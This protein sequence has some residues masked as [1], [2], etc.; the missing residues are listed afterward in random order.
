MHK[1]IIF[2]VY[3]GIQNSVFTSQVLKPLQNLLNK[4]NKVEIS[5]ISFEKISKKNFINIIKQ[6]NS[7]LKPQM[8]NKIKF[9][10]L[11]KLPLITK[12]SLLFATY[13]LNKILKRTSFT[14][15]IARGPLAGWIAIKTLKKLKQTNM[16]ITIQ[17]R[18]LCAQEYRFTFQ[19]LKESLIKK[20]FRKITYK[21][22]NTIEKEVY[23]IKRNN[24]T[25]ESVSPALKNYLI[26][27]FETNKNQIIIASQD[28][29]EKI[30]TNK[31]KNFRKIIREKLN[32]PPD[33]FVY[34]YS[35]SAKPWQC[36]DKAI[37]YFSI[38]LKNN[39]NNFLLIL[40][41][42]QKQIEKIIKQNKI[43]TKNFH[44]IN[45]KPKKLHQYLAACDA[46]LLFRDKDIINWVSRPTKM[47]E[48]Q[49][50]GLKIIHNNTV[51]WLE[52]N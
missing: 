24:I 12:T 10:I 44:L 5:I 6:N 25:F 8:A 34:C 42:D 27:N 14:K 3:D 51:A 46:G 36:I 35:G 26:T 37:K 38:K 4:D 47:L 48:Y 52:N 43:N 22:L 17:A 11:R 20:I 2:I 32:I 9:I 30:K 29:P 40:S 49:A 7:L 19:D 33:S 23:C 45:S 39:P 21:K 13:Q 15:I 50:A 16:P 31:R 41:Q 18:G 1:R 28:I